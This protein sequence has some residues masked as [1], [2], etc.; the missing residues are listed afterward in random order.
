MTVLVVGGGITGLVAAWSLG[1]A[2]VPT[3]LV[4]ATGRLGGKVRT[5]RTDGFLIEHGPDALITYRPAAAELAR[6]LGLGESI[7]RVNEP[8]SVSIRAGGRSVPMP[9]G[10]GLVLPTRML[11]FITTGLLGP[12]QKLRA[13]LDLVLPRTLGSADVG[14]GPFLERRLGRGIVDRL[15]GPLL[16]GVYGTRVGDLS[17]DAVVPS[18]RESERVHRSLMLASIAAGKAR[19]HGGG[20][21]FITLAGGIGALT[22]ALVRSLGQLPGVDV[23]TGSDVASLEPSS[24]GT[25]VRLA[26][27][28]VLRPEAILLATPAPA[29]AGLVESF[30]PAAAAHLRAIPYGSTGVVTL[31]YREEQFPGPVT[32][33]GFLVADDEPLAI[34]AATI[35]SRKWTGRAPDG[36]VLVRVFIGDKSDA[37]L[38]STDDAIVAASRRDLE[39]TLGVHGDQHQVRVTRWV[40]QMP[41]YTVGHIGRVDAALR[42][43]AP[44]PDITVAGSAYRGVGLPD[45]VAQGRAAAHAIIDGREREPVAGD[46]SPID[47]SKRAPAP[48]GAALSIAGDRR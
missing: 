29:T 42:A 37:L 30:A 44:F 2:G 45:C 38:R 27:G 35:T 22:D 12:L 47:A 5:E 46:S 1:R 48:A 33:H 18:L 40:D 9:D 39:T 19:G 32:T 14:I 6:D 26:N 15:A 24:S 17:L 7:I 41:H 13:G 3:V 28:D 43:L 8:R 11:P 20:S 23:R 16:G 4:E 25:T 10:M 31:A 34:S 21:P 36:T